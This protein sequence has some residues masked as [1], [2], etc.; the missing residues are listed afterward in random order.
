MGLRHSD[1]DPDRQ[2]FSRSQPSGCRARTGATRRQA[3]EDWM[4]LLMICATR[5]RPDN[6]A[7]VLGSFRDTAVLPDS[8]VVFVVDDDDPLLPIYREKVPENVEARHSHNM[9]EALQA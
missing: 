6:A 8:D 1:H 2:D 5:G 4:S 9:G 3:S 7:A